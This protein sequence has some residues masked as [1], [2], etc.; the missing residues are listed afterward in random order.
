[1]LFRSTLAPDS[2]CPTIAGRVPRTD[3][4]RTVADALATI[5]V[6]ALP[7][8]EPTQPV[9]DRMTLA[10]QAVYSVTGTTMNGG[11]EHAY[12]LRATTTGDIEIRVLSE[13]EPGADPTIPRRS[14]TLGARFLAWQVLPDGSIWV[15]SGPPPLDQ[16]TTGDILDEVAS[17]YVDGPVPTYAPVPITVP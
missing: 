6:D 12:E 16:A 3:E 7:A 8:L 14:L 10:A 13:I 15:I 17:R 2:G 5:P 1:M 9:D 4:L 11:A